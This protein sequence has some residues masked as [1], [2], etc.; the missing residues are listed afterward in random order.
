[1]LKKNH[2]IKTLSY[3]T[4]Y[5]LLDR[6]ARFTAHA[7]FSTKRKLAGI[8]SSFAFDTLR[9]RR[10]YVI[11]TIQKQ[12]KLSEKEA[13][14]LARKAYFNFL[15][16]SFEMA[17]LKHYSNDILQDKISCNELNH[18][19]EA[20][21]RKKG[22]IIISGHFGLWELVPPW[23]AINGFDVTVVVR[24]Q[25]NPEVDRWMEEMRQK[26][27]AKTTDSGFGIRDILK[28][29]KRGHILALMVDQDNGKQGIFVKFFESWASAP[30]G[31][32]QISLKTGA[33]IVPLAL[34]P[35]YENKHNLKIFPAILPENY[36]ND[37][38]GQQKLTADY[39]SLLEQLIRKHPEQWFWL[40][41]RWKTQPIDAPENPWVKNLNLL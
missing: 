32:A 2:L 34:F 13:A 38:A 16:N 4:Q 41:R 23:L 39:S 15:L 31:P 9:L 21:T 10:K 30:T 27:G 11:A 20:L 33:P 7:S 5:Y 18:L 24:R 19:T 14:N 17:G 3:K 25:N 40:H 6:L 36:T 22:A 29:L 26:H 28:S 8:L 12:L 37:L 1:M 35:D